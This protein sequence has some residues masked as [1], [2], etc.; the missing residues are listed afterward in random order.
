MM[1]PSDL[2]GLGQPVPS[3]VPVALQ[4]PGGG[5]AVLL[6]LE[7]RSFGPAVR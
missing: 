4:R 5:A 2:A 7:R 3:F 6:W 1:P